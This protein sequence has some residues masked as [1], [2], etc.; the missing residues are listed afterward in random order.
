[1]SF[2][3]RKNSVTIFYMMMLFVSMTIN[4]VGATGVKI[5]TELTGEALVNK[6]CTRCHLAPNP[7]DLSKE[8]WSFAV[9]Y[10]G[11]YVG[12]KGDEL[13]GLKM[14]DVPPEWEPEPDYT[15]RYILEDS[16]GY[17]RD[18]YPFKPYIPTEPMMSKAEFKEIR[19]FFVSNA[20]T[21]KEMEIK[22]TKAPLAK[23]FKPVFPKLELEPNTLI[24]SSQVDEKRRR[25]YVGR[26]VI[27]DWVG[28][29]ERQ[30]GFEK[31]DDIVVLNLDTGKRIGHKKLTSD[32]IDMSL[33]ETGVRVMTHGR[34]PMSKVG[35][36]AMTDWEFEDGGS[37]ARMLVNGKQRLVKFNNGD[38]NGDGLEDIVAS[39]FGD[40]IMSD[41]N[42]ELTVYW[43]LPDYGKKWKNAPAEIASEVLTG[44][45][46][47]TIISTQ[48]GIISNAVA[49]MNNDGK[50]DIVALV[51][52]GRQELLVFINNG[53]E[54]F[55]RHLIEENSPSFGGN[56][57][58]VSDFDN[59]GYVDIL[60]LNGDNVAG[61]H[62]G[63]IVPAPRPQHSV[64]VFKNYGNLKFVK[65]FHYP[66]HGATRGVV[67][68]FD[69]DGDDDIAVISLFPQWSEA[70][71]ESFVYL[72]NKGG[73]NFVPQSFSSEYFGVWSSI[74][75]GDV[76]GDNKKDIILGLGDFPELVPADWKTRKIMQGR[77]GN[78][79]S[80]LFLLNTHKVPVKT[81][82]ID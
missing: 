46:R 21:W 8:Y 44:A 42:S 22:R 52:Q 28:G 65:H 34:F 66:M 1:M 20:K 77:E 11:F 40:G 16:E 51:A 3:L 27:D 62:V 36:A 6:H 53:D 47:S 4:A 38:F 50:L 82:K 39:A 48:G 13:E 59:D 63:P 2:L 45:L 37:K 80:I 58:E 73:L 32:P 49:D 7:S 18:L 69:E 81:A 10:M 14:S 75:I 54:T 35:I 17:I 60:V 15:K 33:T 31:W 5:D 9:H 56:N 70:E 64:R 12:M 76:N 43:Q 26:S 23:G 30:E 29:G 55:T 79:Q 78:A 74:E 25:L 24:L 67:Y 71:P 72:E 68:D 19:D 57:V 41:A 61:N